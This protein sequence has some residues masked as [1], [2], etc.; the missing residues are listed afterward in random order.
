MY[1]FYESQLHDTNAA[2][3]AFANSA[4]YNAA[5]TG[6]LGSSGYG[7]AYASASLESLSDTHRNFVRSSSAGNNTSLSSTTP[8]LLHPN[9]AAPVLHRSGHLGM[10]NIPLISL[11][12]APQQTNVNRSQVSTIAFI[13]NELNF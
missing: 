3:Q 5:N 1:Y 13:L 4:G 6:S 2:R 12:P 10:A 11:N 7:S 8:I 9:S